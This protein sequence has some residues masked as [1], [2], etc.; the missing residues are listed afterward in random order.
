MSQSKK[1]YHEDLIERLQDPAEAMGYLK[2]AL[3]ENDMPEIFLAALRDVAEA[4]GISQLAKESN[5]NR[6]NLY[7]MLSKKGNPALKS[8]Y[9]ILDTLGFKLSIQLKKPA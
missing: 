3:E 9:S 5:L 1:N 6:E 4:R 8:L 7:K 2:V